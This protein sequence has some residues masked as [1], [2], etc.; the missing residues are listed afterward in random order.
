[1]RRVLTVISAGDSPLHRAI[2]RV[3]SSFGIEVASVD[4]HSPESDYDPVLVEPGFFAKKCCAPRSPKD[5]KADVEVARF[6]HP[7]PNQ[8]VYFC[9]FA[10]GGGKG[11]LSSRGALLTRSVPGLISRL[12]APSYEPIEEVR[13]QQILRPAPSRVASK[14]KHDV[15]RRKSGAL[16]KAKDFLR[17]IRDGSDD[18]GHLT[19]T[20]KQETLSARIPSDLSSLSRGEITRCLEEVIRGYG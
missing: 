13:L 19:K 8:F 16:R 5:R 18:K 11:N 7:C 6:E 9:P 12:K 20:E 15:A 2:W 3:V 4:S 10:S 17:R 14:I 1:M